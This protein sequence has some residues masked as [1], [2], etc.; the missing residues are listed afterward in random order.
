MPEWSI[1]SDEPEGKRKKNVTY[2][3]CMA[4]LKETQETMTQVLNPGPF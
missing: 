1:D 3:I 4:L 2:G